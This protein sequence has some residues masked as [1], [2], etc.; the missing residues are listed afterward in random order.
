MTCGGREILLNVTLPATATSKNSLPL[1][2]TVLYEP[3]YKGSAGLTHGGLDGLLNDDHR[4]YAS[5]SSSPPRGRFLILLHDA[6]SNDLI[7]TLP[8]LD[9]DPE[10]VQLDVGLLSG[11]LVSVNGRLWR[12]AAEVLDVIRPVLWTTIMSP[13]DK[14]LL[15]NRTE[16]DRKRFNA[17]TSSPDLSLNETGCTSTTTTLPLST[18]KPSHVD[19]PAIHFV[20]Q[21]LAGGVASLAAV[22]LDGSLPL[23]PLE[24]RSKIKRFAKIQT[25]SRK[26]NKV[27]GSSKSKKNTTRKM[28]DHERMD[29][30]TTNVS[31]HSHPVHRNRTR[32]TEGGYSGTTE[33]SVPEQTVVSMHGFGKGRTSALTLGCPPCL[34]GNLKA[35]F[36]TSIIHG[37]DIVCRTTRDS[38][39]RLCKRVDRCIKG[40]LWTR[41]VGW[42]SDT[43]S[44][45]VR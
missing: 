41:K 9:V 16:D 14:V 17:T 15:T 36:I 44:L 26:K 20:G 12:C 43:V 37:D 28:I 25:K 27:E 5:S 23:P 21:S 40:G 22:M 45:T 18:T 8:V 2:I 34:S 4:S 10:F 29:K 32:E 30:K 13:S 1:S 39:N 11:E 31:L 6:Y 24:R 3:N 33:T 7:Q 19:L 35:A 42:V 38:L